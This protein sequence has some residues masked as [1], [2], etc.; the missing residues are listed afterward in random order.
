[1]KTIEEIHD[2]M[3]TAEE[4]LDQVNRMREWAIKEIH[5]ELMLNTEFALKTLAARIKDMKEIYIE[6][7]EIYEGD[8][9][10]MIFT[11]ISELLK[12]AEDLLWKYHFYD[13]S[14]NVAKRFRAVVEAHNKEVI[15]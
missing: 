3:A 2:R 9:E 7:Y 5:E 14:E 8:S 11:D 4:Q 15:K 1:M 13:S 10:E 12:N 6:G